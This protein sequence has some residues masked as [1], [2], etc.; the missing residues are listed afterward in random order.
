M[1]T[2]HGFPELGKAGF[3]PGLEI[4]ARLILARRAPAEI[5][6]MV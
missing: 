4:M 6:R 3:E 2:E 1:Q 5:M